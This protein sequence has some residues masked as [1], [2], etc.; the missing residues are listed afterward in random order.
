MVL[1]GAE[2]QT[3]LKAFAGKW[4]SYRGTERAEAQTFLNEL[5]EA[6]GLNRFDSGAR[7]EDFKS[8]A[9]FMDLHWP[10]V[11]IVEMKRPGTELQTARDQVHRYRMESADEV[12]GIPAA[13][14]V[15]ICSFQQFEIW[16]PGDFPKNPRAIVN[17]SELA[18]RYDVL[19]FLAGAN[20]EPTFTLHDR[21]MTKDAASKVAVMYQSLAERSAAPAPD[22]QRFVMQSV[23]CM[24]AEDLRM[25]EDWP[26]EKTV[27]VLLRDDSRSSAAELGHLFKVLNQKGNHNRQ[28]I[29][30]GTAYVN[31]ELFS[32]PAEVNLNHSELR[33]LREATEF[34][35][36]QVDPTIFGSLMEGVLGDR[37]WELGAHYT[38]EVDIMKI[39]GPSIVKP[40][41]ERIDAADSVDSARALLDALCAYKV[42][43]PACGCGNFLYVAYREL[44]ALESLLKQRI[45][46]LAREQGLS[47]PSG[48]PFVPLTNMRGIEIEP[49]AALIARVTLWMGHRQM[50]DHYGPAESPLPLVT[51]STIQG[52]VD[53]LLIDWPEADCIIGNPPFL[54][55]QRIRSAH[56]DAYVEWLK[57]EF[58]VG[59]KDYCVYWFRRAVN[60]LKPGQRAG[61]V[62]TNSISQ[63]RARSASL[64]YV[65]EQGGVITDAVSS[66]KW[67]GDANVHVSLVNWIA[68]PSEPMPAV[69]DGVGVEAIGSDLRERSA[70]QWNPVK[71]RENSRRC[72]QG[73][74]PVG[75]GFIVDG[76]KAQSLR[77][78]P[79]GTEIVRPYLTADDITT[80]PTRRPSRWIIDFAQLTL[81]QATRFPKALQIVRDEVKPFRATVRRKGH[82]QKWWQF[83]EPRVGL[84]KALNGLE[85]FAVIP[86]HATRCLIEWQPKEVLPSNSCMVFAFDDD[87][88]MAVLQSRAHVAWAWHRS[89]T[90]EVRLRYTPTSVFETFPWPATATQSQRET[91]AEVCNRLLKRRG[92]LCM[93]HNLGLTR[94]Y[95]LMDEGAFEDLR[96]LHK[97]LD[98]AVAQCYGWPKSSAQN[99]EDLVVRLSALNKEIAEGARPY[100][101]FS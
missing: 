24:F 69:L 73:P 28:G 63:N 16:Q 41:M 3:N 99:D 18:E 95:N 100:T 81:E 1:S 6:Y 66:Q 47:A 85:R 38:H 70:G 55:S 39:V 89:S 52:G 88:S 50:I 8:S 57:S 98:E 71:L 51:L 61:L 53:S 10:S 23:W 19:N 33:L 22:L 30:K 76:A 48:L 68:L 31:G 32:Q 20:V 26:F 97:E 80:D 56:G 67:P 2:I 64:E 42:L 62:G 36:S 54:G 94:L 12:E 46:G 43:D 92:E 35:W 7:F 87:F 29:L 11:C 13:K 77:S 84:R 60:H 25:L 37:R 82:R 58:G 15:V 9:G 78:E 79:N 65:V 49:M 17:L 21:Q 45:E 72:F 14:Y 5:F 59:V 101:P 44:R 90:L 40:W 96:A 91:A 83:G 74:I 34:N 86:A 27:D 93:S 75:A 4:E